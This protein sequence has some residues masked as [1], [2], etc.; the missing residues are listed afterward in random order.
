M[1][2][3]Y[4]YLSKSKGF[5][6]TW[7]V[8]RCCQAS[9]QRCTTIHNT[10]PHTNKTLNKS[11]V[12]HTGDHKQLKHTLNTTQSLRSKQKP[13]TKRPLKPQDLNLCAPVSKPIVDPQG[14]NLCDPEKHKTQNTIHKPKGL[15]LCRLGNEN[16][17]AHTNQTTGFEPLPPVVSCTQETLSN[18]LKG[19]NLCHLWKGIPN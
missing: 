5:Y 16:S 19:L 17:Q 8:D 4:L 1:L 2:V 11:C 12:T 18:K 7:G 3:G 9:R 6:L 10:S 14:L 13:F 15:N